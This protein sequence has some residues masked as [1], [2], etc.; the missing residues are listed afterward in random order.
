MSDGGD[1][2]EVGYGR[3]P[4]HTQFKKGQSG[5][6]RGRPKR[7]EEEMSDIMHRVA[8]ER[9]TITINGKRQSMTWAELLARENLNKARKHIGSMNI[10]VNNEERRSQKMNNN[11][12]RWAS[13][14]FG[15][16]SR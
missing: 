16:K 1:D 5:N 14:R 11:M 4:A 2:Y 15:K 13:A 12:V 3:P 9:I 8:M 10:V 7:Q 6:P